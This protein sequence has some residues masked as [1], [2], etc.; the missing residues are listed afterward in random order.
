MEQASSRAHP[1]RPPGSGAKVSAVQHWRNEGVKGELA[2][3]HLRVDLFPRA[4]LN[5]CLSF[6]KV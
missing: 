2:K 6:F 1:L 5:L 3:L 4:Y